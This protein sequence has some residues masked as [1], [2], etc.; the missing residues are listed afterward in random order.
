[1][2]EGEW[3]DDNGRMAA[4]WILVLRAAT[5]Q[6]PVPL[7]SWERRMAAALPLAGVRAERRFDSS[8]M[9]ATTDALNRLFSNDIS[10]IKEFRDLGL[11]AIN[12]LNPVKKFFMLHA[13]GS[14]GS[15]PRLL[16]GEP[17]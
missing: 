10:P 9:L 17:L 5:R 8:V 16:K 14:S 13:M 7:T 4:S 11:A 1:M 15:L 12:K 3:K 6:Y 2:Y